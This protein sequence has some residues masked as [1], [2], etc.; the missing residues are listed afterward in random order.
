MKFSLKIEFTNDYPTV[1]Y[2]QSNSANKTF[3]SKDS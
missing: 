1:N 3:F 2:S